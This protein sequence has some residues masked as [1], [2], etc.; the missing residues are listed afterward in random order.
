MKSVSNDLAAHLAGE[1]LTVATCWKVTRSDGLVFGFTDYCSDLVVS[2]VTYRA[3]TGYTASNVESTGSMSVDNLE[4][5]SFLDDETITESDLIAGVW[6]HA[7]VEI[8]RVNYLSISDGTISVRK[9]HLG[10]IRVTGSGYVGELR[11]LMQILQQTIGAV[12]SPSCRANLFDSRCAPGSPG[13][14]AGGATEASLT[15]TGTVTSVTSVAAFADSSRAEAV[16]Y[17]GGGKVT[18]TSGLNDGLS[19]EIKSFS[20]S[21][22]GFTLMLPM[23]RTIQVGDTYSAIPGCRKRFSADC[24]TKFNNAVNFRGE[25]HVPGLDAIVKRPT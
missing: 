15:V 7:T 6:N 12:Y 5:G 20:G 19:M 10:E 17:F 11:G 8:F 14:L 3:A 4:I 9:G 21:P 18:W 16:D 24:I 22:I 2:G 23:T 1:V 13:A 25:P